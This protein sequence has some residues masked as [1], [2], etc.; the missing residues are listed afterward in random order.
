[1]SDEFENDNQDFDGQD[2]EQQDSRDLTDQG[3]FDDQ[4]QDYADDGRD[5]DDGY[6]DGGYEDDGGQDDGGQDDKSKVPAK[7]RREWE[8]SITTN[9]KVKREEM[10]RKL[11]KAMLFMLVFALIVTSIV[12]IMLLFINENSVRITASSQDNSQSISLSFDND[13]WTP[14]LNAQGPTHIWDVSYSA[15]Y[16]REPIDTKD[17]VRNMLE[18]EN[19]PVGTNNG[20]NFIRFVFM[21]RN[22]GGADV[23]IDYEMTLENDKDSG[24]QKALRVMWGESFKNPLDEEVTDP[25]DPSFNSRTTVEVYAATS[26][27]PKLANLGNNSRRDPEQGYLEYVAYPTGSDSPDYDWTESFGSLLDTPGG[28]TREQATEYGY[29]VST[30]EF[31]DNN[32]VFRDTKMLARGDIMYCYVCI[33]LEG[34]DFDC[35]DSALGGFVSLGINFVAH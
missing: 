31:A 27:N 28:M 15:E 11:K 30:K 16:G 35:V 19:V 29:I 2:I 26:D 13:H 34:S 12:Y 7:M 6:D 9:K 20:E 18:A 1:M 33:W 4:Q 5:Y 25:S 14:Y 21:L 22:N 23:T 32:V 10:R 8:N 17:D 3:N 24:L